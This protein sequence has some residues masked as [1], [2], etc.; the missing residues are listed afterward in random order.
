MNPNNQF[1][2]LY[3]ASPFF[4]T[5]ASY[6]IEEQIEYWGRVQE[7]MQEPQG[8]FAKFVYRRV[9]KY[10]ARVLDEFYALR[11]VGVTEVGIVEGSVD[12]ID[13]EFEYVKPDYD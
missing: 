2:V 9:T 11:S 13:M 6:N 12:D 4:I 1:L 7:L 10:I 8:V 3:F 5:T